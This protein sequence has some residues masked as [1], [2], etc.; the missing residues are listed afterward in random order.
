M[1]TPRSRWRKLFG[2]RGNGT[3]YTRSPL[4][5][6]TGLGHALPPK[7]GYDALV[8]WTRHARKESE[9]SSRKDIGSKR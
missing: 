7:K 5:E 1:G 3:P 4:A 6:I 2:G 8:T 9:W